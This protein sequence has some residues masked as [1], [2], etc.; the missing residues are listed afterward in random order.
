MML[1]I[2]AG[3]V[4]HLSRVTEVRFRIAAVADRTLRIRINFNVWM[5]LK[6][7]SGSDRSSRCH[8]VRPCGANLSRL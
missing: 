5:M 2:G 4:A 7:F 6:G 1:I 3:L 8:N